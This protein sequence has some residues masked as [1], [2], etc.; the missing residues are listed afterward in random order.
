MGHDAT[1]DVGGGSAVPRA[2]RLRRGGGAMAA[3]LPRAARG[4]EQEQKLRP[5]FFADQAASSGT[6]L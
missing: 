3:R 4:G 1:S 2:I 5:V 6:R